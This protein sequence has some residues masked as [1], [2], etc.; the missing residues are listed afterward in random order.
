[1]PFPLRRRVPRS[2]SDSADHPSP[3]PVHIEACYQSSALGFGREVQRGPV[4][5][6]GRW[7][8]G[9]ALTPLLHLPGRN[10]SKGRNRV[11]YPCIGPF[12]LCH[13]QLRIS[14]FTIVNISHMVCRPAE[15]G[16]LLGS[17]GPSVCHVS[18][19]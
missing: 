15:L 10:L 9:V 8:E 2:K 5:G 6:Q 13:K 4:E 19:S 3:S 1:M 14:M 11:H 17:L 7:P 18:S 16:L 12:P